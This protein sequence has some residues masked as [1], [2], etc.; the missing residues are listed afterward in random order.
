MTFKSHMKKLFLAAAIPALLPVATAAGSP[1]L[2]EV[3]VRLVENVT[4]LTLEA[5][6]SAADKLAG[7]TQAN[8]GEQ[9]VELTKQ[10]NMKKGY[11]DQI[12][13]DLG[14]GSSSTELKQAIQKAVE[15]SQDALSALDAN[16]LLGDTITIDSLRQLK[17]QNSEKAASLGLALFNLQSTT[18]A[19]A[20]HDNKHDLAIDARKVAIKVFQNNIADISD[21][22]KIKEYQGKIKQQEAQIGQIER[23]RD[24]FEQDLKD[25]KNS[26]LQSEF[27]CSVDS[28]QLPRKQSDEA[29]LD[30]VIA[31][32]SA[33]KKKDAEQLQEDV[34]YA[35]D[36]TLDSLV[37]KRVLSEELKTKTD[38]I[39]AKSAQASYKI[40]EIEKKL[41]ANVGDLLK[42]DKAIKDTLAAAEK[43]KEA[44]EMDEDKAII[45]YYKPIIEGE[46][47]AKAEKEKAKTEKAAKAA[48]AEELKKSGSTADLD[49]KETEVAKKPTKK[50]TY[51]GG[52]I[53][54]GERE[55]TPEEIEQQKA[56]EAKAAE[57]KKLEEEKA[58]E[59]KKIEEERT[60][61]L[62]KLAKEEQQKKQ[63]AIRNSAKAMIVAE[64]RDL[65]KAKFISAAATINGIANGEEANDKLFDKL[66][67]ETDEL[68]TL[69]A[70]A[71][72]GVLGVV[73]D[74]FVDDVKKQE[75]A[76]TDFLSNISTKLG[77]TGDNALTLKDFTVPA[78]EEKTKEETAKK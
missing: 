12:N 43:G 2:F 42:Y 64:Q 53:T 52:L 51:F 37:N 24:S 14:K 56:E 46:K 44:A 27:F 23:H 9:V 61:K 5:Q 58:A 31:K 15:G 11:L 35:I 8:I 1:V 33:P 4:G 10:G 13:S 41:A 59:L 40:D 49:K 36:G 73:A 71:M 34:G 78:K 18:S 67:L 26:V 17:K 25:V 55:M 29:I 70:K 39:K 48:K 76:L 3:E 77:L 28:D 7:V 57:L 20:M 38:D 19:I 63:K 75:K 16:Q 21:K 74:V 22:E 62:E 68:G 66:V 60:A 65:N 69:R 45:A 32:F 54:W 50:N 6:K 47:K 30:Q 72:Q